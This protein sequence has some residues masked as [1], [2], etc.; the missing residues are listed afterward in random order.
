MI[1]VAMFGI[2]AGLGVVLTYLVHSTLWIL[3]ALLLT[4]LHRVLS[5][6]ARHVV[7][8]AALIGPVASSAFALGLGHRW[9][10]ALTDPS[11]ADAAW[12]SAAPYVATL[13]PLPVAS[14]VEL[15][16]DMAS[17]AVQVIAAAGPTVSWSALLAPG[18]AS[19]AVACLLLLARAVL[20]QRRALAVRTPVTHAAS[21]EALERLSQRAGLRHPVCLSCSAHVSSPLVLSAREICLPERARELD[22]AA[23]DAVLAHELAH[24]ERRD[25]L[26]LYVALVLQAVL[27]FQPLN[28]KVRAELSES[29]ELAADDRAVELTGDALG[30]ART[31]T[32]VASWVSHAVAAPAVAMARAGSPIVE[33]VARLV[34]ASEAGHDS[35]L[36]SRTPWFALAAL[37]AIGACSPSVGAPQAPEPRAPRSSAAPAS[38]S[39]VP[40]VASTPASLSPPA[41]ATP[42]TES[43]GPTDTV[44][45]AGE[46]GDAVEPR[47]PD[48]APAHEVAGAEDARR[49]ASQRRPART[50]SRRRGPPQR[51]GESLDFPIGD[52][53][54]EVVGSV[55]PNAVAFSQ[56]VSELALDEQR[57]QERIRVA[58]SGLA[59]KAGASDSARAELERLRRELAETRARRRRV[60]RD[61]EAGMEAWSKDFEQRFDREFAHRFAAWGEDLGRR[62]SAMGEDIELRLGGLRGLSIPPPPRLPPMPPKSKPSPGPKA[63]PAPHVAPLPRSV[64]NAPSLPS[65]PSP[66]APNQPV[67]NAP[68]LPSV[69]VLPPAPPS[70]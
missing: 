53:V 24:I 17:S 56:S 43:S 28:R 13:R 7:W 16:G 50:E 11:T 29:A 33:R 61:F 20:R 60:E 62:M 55:V 19:V 57:L 31:L 52:L 12:V 63:S 9:Q 27:W 35:R 32:H 25:G 42:A 4:R 39:I 14:P 30:L 36:S 22:G 51:Q 21:I 1:H 54:S 5:P 41:Q 3:G 37:T 34:H 10:W 66:P 68:P 69:P 15:A 67:P 23:L 8:R 47:D 46:P 70:P 64:P 18:W 2:E 40:V 26:W 38:P 58:E 6:A 45:P 48:A 65:V 49:D 44:R 59:G